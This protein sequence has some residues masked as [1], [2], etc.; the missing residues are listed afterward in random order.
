METEI[1]NE[2]INEWLNKKEVRNRYIIA[3]TL[4]IILVILLRY[5]FIK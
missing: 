3:G 4:L 1:L 2:K 5:Y